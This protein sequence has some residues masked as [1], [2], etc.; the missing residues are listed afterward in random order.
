MSLRVTQ[1]TLKSRLFGNLYLTQLVPVCLLMLLGILTIWS[2]SLTIPEAR[3]TSHLFG[4]GLG[5]IGFTVIWQYDYRHLANMITPLFI[6]ACVLLVLPLVPGLGVSAKGMTGWVSFFGFRFQPSEPAK[7]A[8]I[9]LM[10]AVCAQFNGKFDTLRDYI[11]TCATLFIPLIVILV[12]DLGT[13]LVV[14]I[15]GAAIIICSGAPR[16][17]VLITIALIVAFATFVVVTSMIEGL[18]HIL[19]TYQLNRLLVFIDPSIDPAGSGYNLQQ[20]KIAVGSGGLLGKGIGQA[21]QASAGFLPEAHTDFVFALFAE[22]FG[23][24]GSLV[25]LFLFATMIYATIIL[26]IKTE[27]VFSKLVLVGCCA[28]WTFQILEN[29][30]MCIG[31]MPITGIPLPFISYGSSSMITQMAS[32]GLVQSIWRHRKRSA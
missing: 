25:L 19:K 8:V 15:S 31:I 6:L 16:K 27:S 13:G 23:F 5:A 1:H 30:G 7:L 14:F 22:Q 10:A 26:A 29:V 20:A 24:V 11:R 12:T 3:F 2:A 9:L 17:W 28:M 18:P 4:I 21:T 32:V